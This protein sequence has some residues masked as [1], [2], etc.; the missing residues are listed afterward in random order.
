MSPVASTERSVFAPVPAFSFSASQLD[1]CRNFLETRSGST[2]SVPIVEESQLVMGPDGRILE[3]GYRFNAIGFRALA[4]VLSVGLSQLF[5]ELSGEHVRQFKSL[6]RTTDIAAAVSV[7][8]TTLRVR[9]DAL[10]ERNLLVNHREQTIE[11]FLGLDH[12]MLDNSVFLETVRNELADKQPSAEFFRAELLG[13]ELRLYFIDPKSRRTDIYTDP[14]HSFAGGWYFSNREDT[15]NAIRASTCVYTRFGAAIS[16][17]G[18]GGRLNHTGADLIGRTSIL[19]SKVA[20]RAID[21]D[22]V[23]KRV[24][25]LASLSLDFSPDRA[26]MEAANEKWI[27][28]LAKFKVPREDAKQIVKNAAVVGADTEPRDPI[29]VYTKEVLRTRTAYDL[30][31]SI[32]RYSR[33]HYHTLRDMLQTTALKLLIPDVK[34]RK[35]K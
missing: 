18:V 32:L 23:A 20:E 13:R 6:E 4:S 15:G 12:R 25:A 21:M 11:G 35:S 2:E 24:R 14:R 29:D 27:A 28:Y 31:C 1:D 33:G 26:T 7:Y 34:S 17:P 8:N 5:N 3:N 22:V 19:V 9:F 30:F 10:R 16:P